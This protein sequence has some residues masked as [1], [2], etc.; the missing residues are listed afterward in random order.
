MKN[1]QNGRSMIEMLGV[2]AIIGVL[3]AAG[4]AGYQ[5]AMTKNKINKTID[6]MVQ[7]VNNIRMTYAKTSQA[8][9]LY[10][11]ID[12]EQV[13][14]LGL[15]PAEMIASPLDV[16]NDKCNKDKEEDRTN[17]GVRN[18]YKGSVSVWERESGESFEVIF[19]G[20]PEETTVMLSTINWGIEDPSG[21]QEV[22]IEKEGSES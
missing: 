8:K 21:L 4:L 20:L 13:Y 6:Q 18:V 9:K 19:D 10:S 16:T 5:K 2:L 22:K 15:F 1:N 7:I 11:G 12:T 14:N 17:C 3:S